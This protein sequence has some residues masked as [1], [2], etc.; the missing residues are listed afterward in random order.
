MLLLSGSL[1]LI[2]IILLLSGSL[3]LIII[4]LLLSGS[5]PLIQN[6]SQPF[7][8]VVTCSCFGFARYLARARSQEIELVSISKVHSLVM[9]L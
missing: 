8:P 3:P 4:I 6:A 1:P 5:L 2:I 7:Q 9:I